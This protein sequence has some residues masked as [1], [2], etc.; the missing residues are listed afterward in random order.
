MLIA[1]IYYVPDTAESTLYV[2]IHLLLTIIH[3]TDEEIE[4]Q[5]V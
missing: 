1:D 2:L 3:F 5:E 4:T